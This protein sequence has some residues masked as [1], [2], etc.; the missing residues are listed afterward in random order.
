TRP[1]RQSCW[2]VKLDPASP[3]QVE[4]GLAL[5]VPDLPGRSLSPERI[6]DLD[7]QQ[8]ASENVVS[9]VTDAVGLVA[10]HLGDDPLDDDTG[11]DNPAHRSRSFRINLVLSLWRRPTSFRRNAAARRPKPERSARAAS[12]RI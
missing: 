5:T 1:H 2:A 8:I 4:V 7:E 9:A 10:Q 6:R 11:I 12:G 3:H